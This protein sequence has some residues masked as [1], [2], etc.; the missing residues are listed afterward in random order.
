LR[1]QNVGVGTT[2]PQSRLHII[3]PSGYSFPLLRVETD[4]SA[5]PHLI[6]LP[7]GKVGIG[8]ANPMEAL[9][10]SGNIQFSG[11]LMPGGSAGT[12]GF[13]L[14]SQ[15]SGNPP[16]WMDTALLGDDWGSQVAQTQN[17]IV[18]D[19]TGGNPITFA[20]G[21]SAGQ[22]WKWDGSQWVLAKDSV[23]DNWGSQVAVTQ[24]PIVGDGT[25]TNPIGL[26]GGTNA[27][28]VLIWDGT[29]WRIKPS[30][31][32]SVC[33]TAMVNYVQKWTGSELCN[34]IIYDN[35]TQISVGITTP[36]SSAIVEVSDTTR[37]V[38]LPR[39]SEA[40]KVNIS[41]PATGL[42]V[43]QTTTPQDGFWFYDGTR[44]RYM[45]T[46]RDMLWKHSGD[47][48]FS[49]PDTAIVVRG[50]GSPIPGA[51]ADSRLLIVN[52]R[53]DNNRIEIVP[54]TTYSPFP[55][56]K[57]EFWSEYDTVVQ[58][59][60]FHI[61]A[62]APLGFDGRI[63]FNQHYGGQWA[64]KRGFVIYT[65][66]VPRVAIDSLGRMGVRT[67]PSPNV[68]Q[69]IN[70]QP[71]LYV[72]DRIVA[73]GV[74]GYPSDGS[75]LPYLPYHN[76]CVINL[77]DTTVDI[78][79]TLRFWLG[80]C[81]SVILYL[82]SGKTY[83]WNVPVV[84]REFQS[85]LI[86]TPL[87]WPYPS[88]SGCWHNNTSHCGATILMTK[89]DTFVASNG[90]AYREPWKT[91][92]RSFSSLILVQVTVIDSSQVDLPLTPRSEVAGLFNVRD[93]ARIGI[94]FSDV[95]SSEHIVVFPG[96]HWG[97]AGFGGVDFVNVN[98]SLRTIHPVVDYNGWNFRGGGGVVKRSLPHIT[99]ASPGISWST[100]PDIIYSD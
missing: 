81:K 67:P 39:M 73:R 33:G 7:D 54:R 49:L 16:V 23:G 46:D 64:M 2:S 75:E 74:P 41:N 91:I 69:H 4:G 83:T 32:D 76:P 27:G 90:T 100:S 45:L 61:N 97:F 19:G 15:G 78:G 12:T 10:V 30:P 94:Y 51:P 22:V 68:W 11:A 85:V 43:Y 47:S 13:V 86:R 38:L 87:R 72:N 89:V 24:G 93:L 40:N 1:A 66:R 80:R 8:V 9:D 3:A 84:I 65:K 34:S 5:S 50:V 29:Q 42:L 56:Q 71:T 62:P 26:Q 55:E 6:V 77:H 88:G 96:S 18:G 60:D 92:L 35:G 48:L 79:D 36:H 58:V 57:I 17:P 53:V 14:M 25:T 82:D 52:S 21:T 99:F 31:F 28:D 37:G 98:P 95:F 44:W 59:I 20:S 70:E 63:I